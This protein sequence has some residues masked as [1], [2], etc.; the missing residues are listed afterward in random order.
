MPLKLACGDVQGLEST[1]P[2][3]WRHRDKYAAQL[4]DRL[5]LRKLLGDDDETIELGLAIRY[6]SL[7]PCAF[8]ARSHSGS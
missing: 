8:S 1:A 6:V 4:E 5:L 2:H 3:L 7:Q